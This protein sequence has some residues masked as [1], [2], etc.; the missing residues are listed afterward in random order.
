[1]E[2]KKLLPTEQKTKADLQPILSKYKQIQV[3]SLESFQS[4]RGQEA[5]QQGTPITEGK[6]PRERRRVPQDQGKC[7]GG[8]GKGLLDEM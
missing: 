5:C 2:M 4:G 6:E 7:K 8:S 1:M 3:L